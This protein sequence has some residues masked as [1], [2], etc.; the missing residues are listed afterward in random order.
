MLRLGLF[1]I[2]LSRYIGSFR[3]KN[4]YFFHLLEKNKRFLQHKNLG[5]LST[6]RIGHGDLNAA[7]GTPPKWFL[8]YVR[9]SF[10]FF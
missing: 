9:I 7:N 6:L 4:N 2:R 1:R 10:L 3:G 8:D 5:M